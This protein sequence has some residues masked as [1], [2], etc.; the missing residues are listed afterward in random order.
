M[1]FKNVKSLTRKDLKSILGGQTASCVCKYGGT[2]TVTISSD[3]TSDILAAGNQACGFSGGATRCV[4]N[5]GPA[6]PSQDMG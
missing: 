4:S 2:V 6:S 3:S 5:N 1:K